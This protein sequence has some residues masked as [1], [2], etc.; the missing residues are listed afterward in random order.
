MVYE[1][2]LKIGKIHS[3]SLEN[4]SAQY[5]REVTWPSA[6]SIDEKVPFKVHN[7]TQYLRAYECW[8]RKKLP[9]E[10]MCLSLRSESYS[11]GANTIALKPGTVV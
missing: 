8:H 11:V 1:E 3:R 6:E 2:L 7:R 5:T 10:V 9:L 4:A